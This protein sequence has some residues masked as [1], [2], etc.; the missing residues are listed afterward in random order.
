MESGSEISNV[1]PLPTSDRAE[2]S[3][4]C[5]S[6]T[7]DTNRFGGLPLTLGRVETTADGVGGADHIS[8]GDGS[9]VVLGGTGADSIALGSGTNLV[10]GDDGFIDWVVNDGDPSDIDLAASTTPADGG[11]DTITIGTGNNLIVGGAG[12][13]TISGGSTSNVILGDNSLTVAG[14]CP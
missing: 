11:N 8:T 12:A 4:P 3:P 13:D 1:D 9:D 5:A 14:V 6:A 10:F 7:A 2:T